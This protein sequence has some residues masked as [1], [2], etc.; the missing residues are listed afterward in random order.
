MIT[1]EV[2][3]SGT[4]GKQPIAI[5]GEPV[6][7]KG[8]H[9]YAPTSAASVVIRSGATSGDLISQS[10]LPLDGAPDQVLFPGGIRF[11]KGMHVKVLGVGSACYLYLE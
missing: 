2:T 11:D 7:L 10:S 1:K 6:I 4:V 9:L 3:V 5:T 8:Y